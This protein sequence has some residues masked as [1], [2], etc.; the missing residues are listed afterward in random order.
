[1]NANGSG[2]R[3]LISGGGHPVWS[4]D[5]RTIAYNGSG[6]GDCPP[7]AS[8][9]GHTV[10]VRIVRVDGSADRVLSPSSRNASWSPSGRRVAYEAAI[11]PYGNAHAIHVANADGTK[12]RRVAG[13]GAT[14][15]ASPASPAWSPD[16][17]LIA[18]GVNRA[19]YVVRPDGTGRRRL[20]RAL[21]SCGRWRYRRRM[22]LGSC[23]S[24]GP[25]GPRGR[26]HCAWSPQA[27]AV[28]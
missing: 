7:G 2:Q 22:A 20:A 28:V 23:T 8:R 9:C 5:G 10:A 25:P 17:R 4:P 15:A 26:S 19:I 1:M 18:Y 6:P 13:G 14:V 16:G 12:V 24:V 21:R 11:D 27:E 3:Q